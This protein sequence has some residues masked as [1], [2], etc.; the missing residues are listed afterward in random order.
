MWR[1]IGKSVVGTSHLK[2]QLPCQ[3][4]S[5]YLRCQVGGEPV[6]VIGVSDGAGSAALSHIGSQEVVGALL[7]QAACCE[8]AIADIN[9]EDVQAWFANALAHLNSVAEREKIETKD[10]ACTVLVA[11]LGE[12]HRRC[13]ARSWPPGASCV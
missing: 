6:L 8:R 4:Y 13:P 7:R 12:R 1:A 3:D 9:R 11:I 5:D 2:G 10:L